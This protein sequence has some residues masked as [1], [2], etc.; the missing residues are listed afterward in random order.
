MHKKHKLSLFL[1]IVI[2]LFIIST[3]T[4][5]QN[6]P[7]LVPLKKNNEF[8]NLNL[9]KIEY[10]NVSVISDGYAGIYWND[11]NSDLPN[12][13]VDDSGG[14]HV[15]WSDDTN[16]EWGIDGEIMFTHYSETTGWSNATVISDGYNGTYWNDGDSGWPSIAVDNL[17][18]VHV[19]WI[20]DTNGE[21]G[22]DSEIMFT[23]YTE[24]TGWSNA[25]VISDGYN[26]TYWT[27]GYCGFPDIAVDD[28]GV[29]HVVWSD[30]TK[31]AWTG[32][33]WETDIM[34]VNYTEAT[35]WSNLTVISDGYNGT[36][37][38]D[39]ASVLPK[40]ATDGAGGVHVVWIDDTDGVWGNDYEIM[41]ANFTEATGWSN[42]TVI[43]DGYNNTYWNDGRSIDPDITVDDSGG[44]HVVWEDDTDGVWGT[45]IEIMYVNYQKADGWSNPT[46]I[47]DG[48]NGIYWNHGESSYPDIAVDDSGGIHVVWH[49]NTVG[50]WGGGGLEYE[51]IFVNNLKANGWSNPT[52]ISDGYNGIYWNDDLSA[53]PKI[54]VDNSRG[55]YVVWYDYTDGA[56]GTDAE[57]MFTSISISGTQLEVIPSGNFSLIIMIISVL[58]LII[59]LKRKL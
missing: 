23:H 54:A 10:S 34:Y 38:N 48:C 53:I 59:Y 42:V 3:L 57:I 21:W 19:V 37:W 15:V 46:V 50:L 26:G 45:D 44:I 47:S 52:V 55:I 7:S 20:D 56:W 5:R 4:I 33:M 2:F 9:S 51:I 28:S 17:G 27:D 36:Y 43:S 41:Y 30:E 24:A 35:G 1:A 13:A 25:T 8:R 16:G 12:I 31:G 49:D 11:G 29:I 40:I 58:G 32:G 6:L 14:I 22:V 39:G 18:G